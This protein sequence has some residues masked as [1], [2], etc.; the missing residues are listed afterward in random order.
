LKPDFFEGWLYVYVT[1]PRTG[2]RADCRDRRRDSSLG[3]KGMRVSRLR[4]S[5]WQVFV[6]GVCCWMACRGG[7]KRLRRWVKVEA[8]LA[9]I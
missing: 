8:G 3:R 2:A 9:L 5:E 7:S 6:L 1:I 4:S